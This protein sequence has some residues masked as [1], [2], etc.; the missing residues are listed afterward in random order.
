M[1][2]PLRT[3]EKKHICSMKGCGNT[4]TH[5]FCRSQDFFGALY[6]CDTCVKEMY[7]SVFGK[8]QT[9]TKRRNE[10]G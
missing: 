1:T 4:D 7:Q 5:L 3:K 9:K 2:R 10:N 8:T 6:L